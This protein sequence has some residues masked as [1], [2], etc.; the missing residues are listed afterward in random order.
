M[1]GGGWRVAT[2]G[3]LIS[4]GVQMLE[5]PGAPGV[6]ANGG[7]AFRPRCGRGGG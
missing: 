2:T 6:F 5:T 7:S 4:R 3:A 1:A